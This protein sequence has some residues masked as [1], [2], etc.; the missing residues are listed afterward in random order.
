MKHLTEKGLLSIAKT[1]IKNIT[2]PHNAKEH[3]Q[4]FIT[5]KNRKS[6]QQ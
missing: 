3:Y 5:T 4:S 6:V 2:D 1:L